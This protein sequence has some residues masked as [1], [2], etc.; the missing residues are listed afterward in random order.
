MKEFITL[1]IR[2]DHRQIILL[3]KL[4]VKRNINDVVRQTD[5]MIIQFLW[6]NTKHVF[7]FK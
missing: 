6:V 2:V 5:P 3:S 7:E 1:I 4:K